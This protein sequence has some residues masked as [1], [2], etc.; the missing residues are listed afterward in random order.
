MI[1]RIHHHKISVSDMERSLVFYRDLLGFEVIYDALRENLP[2]YDRIMALEGVRVRVVMLRHR[3]GG[4]LIGLLQ[5]HHPTPQPRET[6]VYSPGFCTLALEADDIDADYQRLTQAG[7]KSLSPVVQI[8]R[9][10]KPVAKAV[11]VLDPD[12]LRIELYQPLVSIEDAK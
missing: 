9:G 5:F 11:Y 8:V 4:P 1:T 10:G 12:G 2:S 6:N 3:A 7:V